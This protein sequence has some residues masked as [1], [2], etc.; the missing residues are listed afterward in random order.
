M[1][2]GLIGVVLVALVISVGLQPERLLSLARD[3]RY[4]A[5]FAEAGGLAAGNDVVV[6]GT[7]VGHVAAVTLDRTPP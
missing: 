3:L 2:A 5:L 1:R 7:A 4:D 6:S